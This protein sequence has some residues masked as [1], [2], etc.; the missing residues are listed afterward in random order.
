MDARAGQRGQAR[1]PQ[2][3]RE[4]EEEARCNGRRRSSRAHGTAAA[5]TAH[6]AKERCSRWR[7]AA[8]RME[9]MRRCLCVCFSGEF[10][11]VVG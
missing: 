6:D 3:H 10:R 9:E 8:A 4:E 2:N 5:T 1:W 11:V 7:A